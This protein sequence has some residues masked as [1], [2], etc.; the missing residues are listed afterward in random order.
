MAAVGDI[1]N[2]RIIE[3]HVKGDTIDAVEIGQCAAENLLTA[4]AKKL[5]ASYR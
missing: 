1:N 5:L 4:G 3:T 2:G